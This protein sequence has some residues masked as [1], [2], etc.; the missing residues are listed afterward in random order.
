MN[1]EYS[2]PYKL[3]KG[4]GGAAAFDLRA[5]KTCQFTSDPNNNHAIIDTGVRVAIP[6]GYLGLV[7]LRSGIGFKRGFTSHIGIIDSDYRGEIKVKVFWNS[8]DGKVFD[9]ID[10][11]ER[12]AQLTIIPIPEV[13]PVEVDYLNDTERG[14]G[15][16]GSTGAK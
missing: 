8:P 9:I 3:I 10:E 13:T 6:Y 14:E 11:G 16:F 12:F 5:N 1:L 2:A 7:T 15:G 4:S